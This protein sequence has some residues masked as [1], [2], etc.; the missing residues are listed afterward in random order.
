MFTTITRYHSMQELHGEYIWEAGENSSIGWLAGA[1]LGSEI[2]RVRFI[3][4]PHL[5]KARYQLLPAG[6]ERFLI[7][8]GS[9]TTVMS[10]GPPPAR[11]RAQRRSWRLTCKGSRFPPQQYA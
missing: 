7:I 11:R 4:T 6:R 1:M 10:N 2:I 8:P 5:D 3:H 9:S